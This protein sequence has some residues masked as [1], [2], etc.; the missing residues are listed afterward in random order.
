MCTK[1]TDRIL[2]YLWARL[3]PFSVYHLSSASAHLV[4]NGNVIAVCSNSS[5]GV[6]LM[7]CKGT[8]I[9]KRCYALLQLV[10]TVY[11]FVGICLRLIFCF[12]CGGPLRIA[13][14]SASLF[15]L[16]I[17]L[18]LGAVIVK[19]PRTALGLAH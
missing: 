4:G 9:E 7:S 6:M 16:H 8:V 18:L 14:V 15:L 12:R 17:I 2:V 1:K 13:D 5:K 10:H 11:C 3:G 19:E